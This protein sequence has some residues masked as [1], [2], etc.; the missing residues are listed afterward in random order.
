MSAALFPRQL[1]QIFALIRF[2][3]GLAATI[4]FLLCPADG[5]PIMQ[6]VYIFGPVS[7][8]CYV[9]AEY[10]NGPHAPERIHAPARGSATPPPLRRRCSWPTSGE[11][12][13]LQW[14]SP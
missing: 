3:E 10:I 13:P 5:Q 4:G 2:A 8:L 7:L 12:I 1:E 14:A 11:S 9:F 6:V